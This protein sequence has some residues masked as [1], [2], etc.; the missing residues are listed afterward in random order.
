[1]KAKEWVGGGGERKSLR[2]Q[3]RVKTRQPEDIFFERK[4]F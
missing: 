1:M 4:Q 3:R 2:G